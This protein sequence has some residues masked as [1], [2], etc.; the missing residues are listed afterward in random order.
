MPDFTVSD[1]MSLAHAANDLWPDGG[2]SAGRQ[3]SQPTPQT[4]VRGLNPRFW[5]AANARGG[6]SAASVSRSQALKADRRT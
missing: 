5:K 4:A 2:A 3:S 1:R 6:V